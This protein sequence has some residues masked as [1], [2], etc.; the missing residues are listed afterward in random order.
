[1]AHHNTYIY[2]VHARLMLHQI[3]VATFSPLVN[4]ASML[5]NVT[6]AE[7]QIQTKDAESLRYPIAERHTHRLA[8]Q[9]Y[10]TSMV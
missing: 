9:Y 6:A 8:Y 5:L 1:M 2:T 7:W 3:P 10:S 4:T